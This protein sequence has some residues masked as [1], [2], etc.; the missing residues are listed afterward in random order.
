MRD[1]QL[2]LRQRG[3]PGLGAARTRDTEAAIGARPK[4]NGDAFITPIGDMDTIAGRVER[5]MAARSCLK[6]FGQGR[7]LLSRV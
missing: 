6:A 4:R 3:L 2:A 7:D 1:Q 5:E